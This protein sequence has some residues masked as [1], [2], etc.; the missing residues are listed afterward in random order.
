[1]CR[2]TDGPEG[3][4][5]LHPSSEVQMVEYMEEAGINDGSIM[6]AANV[7]WRADRR[8]EGHHELC[9]RNFW[10]LCLRDCGTSFFYHIHTMSRAE[11]CAT[12]VRVGELCQRLLYHGL[13]YTDL[14]PS[15]VCIDAAGNVRLV[16]FG[17]LAEVGTCDACATY[18]PP[19]YPYGTEVPATDE[20]VAYGIGALWAVATNLCSKDVDM[21]MRHLCRDQYLEVEDARAVLAANVDHAL[22]QFEGDERD[23]LRMALQ[24]SAPLDVVLFHM[25]SCCGSTDP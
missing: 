23:V 20:T 14:K 11:V 15:N 8:A 3:R 24:E 19:E 4:H 18:P 21:R 12:V 7:L 25:R 13:A 9:P 17:A 1:M 2:Y 5:K 22:T 6:C 16:D 10:A